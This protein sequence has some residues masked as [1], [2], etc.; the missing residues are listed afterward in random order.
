MPLS[1]IRKATG[2]APRPF[3]AGAGIRVG[4]FVR[5]YGEKV[6]ASTPAEEPKPTAPRKRFT[7]T[8]S[9]EDKRQSPFNLSTDRQNRLAELRLL[10]NFIPGDL[11]P[12]K[13]PEKVSI[14]SKVD[15]KIEDTLDQ[16]RNIQRRQILFRKF[17]TP[18]YQD[19]HDIR[20][21]SGKLFEA[22]ESEVPEQSAL[23]MP[24]MKVK[25][26]SPH[27]DKFK[28]SP[29]SGVELMDQLQGKL[30]LVVFYLSQYGESQCRSFVSPFQELIDKRIP[31][32][33]LIEINVAEK[34]F[35]SLIVRLFASRIRG[36]L[37]E[38][39]QANYYLKYGSLEEIREKLAMVNSMM[40]YVFL[41]DKNLKVRWYANGEAT[42]TELESMKAIVARLSN[43]KFVV[44]P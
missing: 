3:T 41:V 29:K 33:Q 6:Q 8:I 5:G 10:K 27:L 18:V 43:I 1:I 15:R 30:T 34:F 38:P 31:N 2:I 17:C 11:L 22:I 16:E 32:L 26:L 7:A 35:N 44:N 39:K 19:F 20:A 25:P 28:D 9:Y 21:T 23:Y 37:S 24:N 14:L 42:Q 40:G 4:I 36:Q 13:H 12:P